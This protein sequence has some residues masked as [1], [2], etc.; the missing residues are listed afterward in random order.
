MPK[1]QLRAAPPLPPF[2]FFCY[3]VVWAGC[4]VSDIVVHCTAMVL[5]LEHCYRL[6]ISLQREISRSKIRGVDAMC[7]VYFGTS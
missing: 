6:L 3:A 1:L 2:S 4:V 5:H 7:F